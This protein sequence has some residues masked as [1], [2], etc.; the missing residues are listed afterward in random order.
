MQG[1]DT[2]RSALRIRSLLATT[3]AVAALIAGS[4]NA[5]SKEDLSELVVTA[6]PYPV[7]IDSVTTSVHIL[8]RQALDLAPPTGLG[9]LLSGL[10]G[11]RSTFYGP[12]ASRPI[13]R[14]LS[15]PRVLVLQNGVGLVDAST[16]SPDHAVA[17]DPGEASRIEVLRGPSALAY[18]GSAIGGVVNIL[19]D[20]VPSTPA[21][22]L[23]GRLSGSYGTV[24]DGYALSGGLKAG[25][26]PWVVAL[27]AVK[28][29]SGDYHVG[30]PPVSKRLADA[31]GLTRDLGKTVR[32]S[33]VD[34]EAYG[35]GL[36]YIGADGYLGAS[37]KR[38]TTVYGVPYAQVLGPVDPNAEGPVEIHLRQTRVD[39]RGEHTLNLGPF[40]KVRAAFGW[41]D[42]EH[43]EIAAD[44]GAIGTRFLSTGAEGRLELVQKERNGW[45][46]AVGFQGLGRSFEA[47][48]D[49]AF[50]PPSDIREWGVFTLQRLDKGAWG[51]EGGLRL[52]RRRVSAE[53][54]STR[55]ASEAAEEL[56]LD[57]AAAPS[58][59]VF[60]NVSG[61]AA[62][63]VRPWKDWFASVSISHNSRAPTETEL[64]AD[65]P[66]AGTRTFEIGDP[67][68]TREKVT[69]IEA[70]LRY[71]GD[72]LRLEGHGYVAKYSGFIEETPTGGQE[73]SL[74]IYRFTQ[75]GANFVGFELEGSYR[76]WRDGERSLSLEAGADWVRG[77]TDAG[78]PPRIPP[79]S[80]SGRIVFDS[81]R[82][83]A[84][85]ETRRVGAQRRVADYELPTDG[86]TQVNARVAFT[87]VAGKA[88]KLFVEGRNLTDTVAREHTSFLKDIAPLPGR[89]IRFGAAYSF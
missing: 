24:D 60:T 52:D 82:F 53:G 58:R 28:R 7:S 63:F 61:S 37:V 20:R 47:I 76:V 69:S 13:I 68:L 78:P 14:G 15:G 70:G 64:F 84:H 9:D 5:Q 48:G 66:H 46:G 4:A 36:S 71:T 21:P 2:R 89:N 59:R 3:A 22:H 33:G 81:P 75:Q 77:K 32:N 10:P 62:A 51:I 88:L 27:D 65:G 87:P 86:Y 45:Q 29:E 57:W 31:D 26:G 50:I 43:A 74:P 42:Y 83:E 19:D 34:L 25:P 40:E 23:Q 41:A 1:H 11:V 35:A 16:I 39:V 18:G 79:Y 72:G 73:D 85:V 44:T 55:E 6:A 67:N 80:I 54:L 49:E 38:T 12:G 30:G 17:S 56:G 8:N